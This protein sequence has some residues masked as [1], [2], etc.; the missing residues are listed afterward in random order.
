MGALWL[1]GRVGRGFLPAPLG[2]HLV[3]VDP[4]RHW[5]I[6]FGLNSVAIQYSDVSDFPRIVANSRKYY[7]FFPQGILYP[8]AY[9]LGDSVHE[10]YGHIVISAPLP[11][12]IGIASQCWVGHHSLTLGDTVNGIPEYRNL[13]GLGLTLTDGLGNLGSDGTMLIFPRF[14]VVLGYRFGGSWDFF[15]C[16]DVLPS[17]IVRSTRCNY[18]ISYLTYFLNYSLT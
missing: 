11:T 8:F 4:V 16:H 9:L 1:G 12:G 10:H 13:V 2:L 15:R 3:D 14:Y 18:Y 17:D 6:G 5:V 7:Q